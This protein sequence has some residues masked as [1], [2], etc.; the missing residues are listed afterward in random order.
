MFA[1]AVGLQCGEKH[2]H[3]E[4]I[5]IL[6]QWSKAIAVT[7][8]SEIRSVPYTPNMSLLPADELRVGWEGIHHLIHEH[9]IDITEYN[10]GGVTYI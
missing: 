10:S 3:R 6:F 1:S 2:R 7:L 4:A 8:I 9:T 5:Y